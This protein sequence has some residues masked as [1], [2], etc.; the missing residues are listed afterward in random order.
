[1]D[2]LLPGNAFGSDLVEKTRTGKS[3]KERKHDKEAHTLKADQTSSTQMR[4]R[5]QYPTRFITLVLSKKNVL[6]RNNASCTDS[7]ALSFFN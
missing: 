5:R 7:S 2:E 6:I 4:S 3:E 1:M